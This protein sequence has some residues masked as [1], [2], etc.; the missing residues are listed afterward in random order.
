MND[1]T[2]HLMCVAGFLGVR[3]LGLLFGNRDKEEWEGRIEPAVTSLTQRNTTQALFHVGTRADVLPDAGHG[4]PKPQKRYKCFAD[5]FEVRI[6]R[7]LGESGIGKRGIWACNHL[8]HTTKHNKVVSRQFSVKPWYHSGRA[9]P[10]VPKHGSP[11]L[12]PSSLIHILLDT[13]EV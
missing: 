11:T 13:K 12:T 5:L 3:N 9:G 1:Q 4:Y 8:T 6:L 2:Y 10:F 7:V